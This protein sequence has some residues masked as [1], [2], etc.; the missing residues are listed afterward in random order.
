MKTIKITSSSQLG[1]DCKKWAQAKFKDQYIFLEDKDFSRADVLFSLFH[2][3]IFSKKTLNLFKSTY[4]FH[5]GSLPDY[6]GSGSP[7]WSIINGENTTAIT[8]HEITEKLDSGNIY[9]EQRLTINKNDTG[10]TLYDRLC[11]TAFD[12]FKE[13]F[14]LLVE[15]KIKPKTQNHSKKNVLYTKKDLSSV[16][17]L[18]NYIKALNHSSKENAYFYNSKGKKI[19]IKYD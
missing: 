9:I 6:R 18:T 11:K 5:G 10:E 14:Q 4:N 13:N 16:K 7:I 17:N 8:V 15:N 3:K 2:N 12:I 1:Q 19:E